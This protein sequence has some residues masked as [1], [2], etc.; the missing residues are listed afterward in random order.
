[1]C[2]LVPFPLKPAKNCSLANASTLFPARIF[3][4]KVLATK[5]VFCWNQDLFKERIMIG[6]AQTRTTGLSA[7]LGGEIQVKVVN[8]LLTINDLLRL[9]LEPVRKCNE[10]PGH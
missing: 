8:K 6:T 10:L 2:F 9:R 7:A 5:L 3:I 1:V 4:Q